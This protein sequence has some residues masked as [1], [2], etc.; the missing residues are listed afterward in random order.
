[1]P[2]GISVTNKADEAE[3]NIFGEI[4]ETKWYDDD[5]TPADFKQTIAG[6]KDKKRII[7]NINSPGGGVFAGMTIYNIIKSLPS[8]TVGVVHGM[9]AS[10]AS[11]ILQ[12]CD[13][14]VVLAGAMVMIHKPQSV[15][16]GDSVEIRKAADFLDK[17]QDV[18][19]SRYTERTII[20]EKVISKMMDVET[21]LDA[22]EA[23]T[24]GFADG[25]EA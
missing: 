20:N 5:V 13:R 2:Y 9:A 12:A 14:R 16:F 3:I 17:I 25:I 8:E 19:I 18:I 21:W 15:A 4:A 22:E 11:V 24:F 1:M 6:L 23:V 10:I 7:I